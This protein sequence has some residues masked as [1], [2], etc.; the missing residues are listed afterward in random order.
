[1]GDQ[2]ITRTQ[3]SLVLSRCIITVTGERGAPGL[4]RALWATL[5]PTSCSIAGA[6]PGCP[7]TTR[8]ENEQGD[9]EH[10]CKLH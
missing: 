8:T 9:A 10:A 6:G 1:M 7:G 4:S 3:L 5:C 2:L